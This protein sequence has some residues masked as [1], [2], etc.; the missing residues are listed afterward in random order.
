MITT[1]VAKGI[2]RGRSLKTPFGAEPLCLFAEPCY[3][4]FG[5]HAQAPN[6][7]D[8]A[9]SSGPPKVVEGC[10]ELRV[11]PLDKPVHLYVPLVLGAL[12]IGEFTYHFPVDPNAI[13]F[14]PD[15]V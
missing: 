6:N 3:F 5:D 4:L 9:N 1:A 11:F 14:D 12:R 15:R 2:V 7:T 13:A 10:S 8:L